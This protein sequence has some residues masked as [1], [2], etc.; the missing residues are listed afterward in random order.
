MYAAKPARHSGKGGGDGVDE[1]LD[2]LLATLTTITT[3]PPLPHPPDPTIVGNPLVGGTT[4][5]KWVN[6]TTIR[7]SDGIPMGSSGPWH[8]VVPTSSTAF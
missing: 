2:N 6:V 7:D 3:G 5:G 4:G 1:H 8:V